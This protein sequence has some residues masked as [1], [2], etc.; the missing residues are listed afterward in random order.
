M[1]GKHLNRRRKKNITKNNE[2]RQNK[3]QKPTGN[4]KRQG[5]VHVQ[6]S[7]GVN[8]HTPT[9]LWTIRPNFTTHNGWTNWRR[10]LDQLSQVKISPP[11]PSGGQKICELNNTGTKGCG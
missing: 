9:A 4:S 1:T 7:L 3:G 10:R 5:K 11:S 8:V 6:L 2:T